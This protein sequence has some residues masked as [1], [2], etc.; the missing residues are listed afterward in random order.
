[1]TESTD[2]PKVYEL[3]NGGRSSWHRVGVFTDIDTAKHVAALV[4]DTY[5]EFDGDDGTEQCN[6][7]A[8][9]EMSRET[10]GPRN[11]EVGDPKPFLR[12]GE[13]GSA[14]KIDTIILDTAKTV[15]GVIYP[16]A[17]ADEGTR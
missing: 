17:P 13:S 16:P 11:R 8:T 12:Y 7:E 10:I 14:F 6:Y 9:W 2:T 15:T 5:H 4:L 3:L 1:M